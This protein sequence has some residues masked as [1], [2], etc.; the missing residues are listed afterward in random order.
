MFRW[1]REHFIE[2]NIPIQKMWDIYINPSNWPKWVDQFDF[3][4][5]EGELKPGTIIKTKIKNRNVYIQIKMTKLKPYDECEL[6]IKA[7]LFTQESSCFFQ[8]ISTERTLLIMKTSVISLL[9]PFL[10]SFFHKR[11]EY[12]N[13]KYLSVFSEIAKNESK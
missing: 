9:V 13:S 1:S 3:C 2:V 12:S 6:L 4:T 7:P 11:L 8:E 5:F 10:K